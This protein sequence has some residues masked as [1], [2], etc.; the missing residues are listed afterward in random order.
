MTT[1]LEFIE[2]Q[3]GLERYAIDMYLLIDRNAEQVGAAIARGLSVSDLRAQAAEQARRG[4][5][6]LAAKNSEQ[7]D[8]LEQDPRL[9]AIPS[10]RAWAAQPDGIGQTYINWY[11]VLLQ[12]WIENER[13]PQLVAAE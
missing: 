6:W 5:G 2:Q 1:F 8:A 7:A 12:A 3:P 10:L 4:L 11:V 9:A 13:R